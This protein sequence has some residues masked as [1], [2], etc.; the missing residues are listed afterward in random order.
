MRKTR[1][2]KKLAYLEF[3]NDQLLTEIKYVDRL[4]KLVGF[5]NGLETVKQASKEILSDRKK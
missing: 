4:L 1:L 5:P 3:V 2:L